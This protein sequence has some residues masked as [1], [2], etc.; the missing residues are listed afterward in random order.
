M[1]REEIPLHIVDVGM[2]NGATDVA[3]KLVEHERVMI[4]FSNNEITVSKVLEETSFSVFLMIE[5]HRAA[6][7]VPFAS[8]RNLEKAVNDLIKVARITPPADVY[9]PLPEGPFKY[10]PALLEA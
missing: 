5:N 7:V 9:A 6:T 10:D 8:I 4:R 2:K 1:K 3:A